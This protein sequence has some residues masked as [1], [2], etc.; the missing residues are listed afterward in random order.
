M[1]YQIRDR[2]DGMF[3]LVFDKPVLVGIF[4]ERDGA[5][6]YCA[7]LNDQDPELPEDQPASFGQALKDVAEAV[8]DL[9]EISPPVRNSSRPANLPAVVPDKPKAPAQIRDDSAAGMSDEETA[10]AFARIQQ[11]EKVFDVARDF[12]VSGEFAAGQM[13]QAQA[14]PAETHGRGW[15]AALPAL[16]APVHAVDQQS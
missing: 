10:K 5:E 4:P 7:F 9:D 2:S 1:S 16:Q 12:S 6:K 13:G 11:G 8:S 15:P 3:E 14:R